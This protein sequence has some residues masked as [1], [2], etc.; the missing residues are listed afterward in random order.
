MGSYT[1]PQLI[2]VLWDRITR[3]GPG[4]EGTVTLEYNRLDAAITAA[5]GELLQPYHHEDLRP[6]EEAWLDELQW[7]A[8]STA[9]RLAITSMTQTVL[10]ALP[11]AP[12]ALA[13]GSGRLTVDLALARGEQLPAHLRQPAGTDA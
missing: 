12:A 7:E 6:S 3:D 13:E 8:A 11:D 2:D 4:G 10:A 5:A 9:L 1:Q